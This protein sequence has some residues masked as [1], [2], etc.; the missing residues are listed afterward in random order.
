VRG[1][2]HQVAAQAGG[3]LLRQEAM[4]FANA[5]GVN[6]KKL[7]K[8]AQRLKEAL[9]VGDDPLLVPLLTLTAQVRTSIVFNTETKHLKLIGNLYDNCQEALVQYAEFLQTT[10]TDPEE[11]SRLMPSLSTLAHDYKLEPEVCVPLRSHPSQ[12]GVG[13]GSSP[14]LRTH[15]Q[16]VGLRGRR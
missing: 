12:H 9:L 13:G 7:A 1:L 6:P 15:L 2:L 10:I 14:G 4:T 8:G 11:Y 16:L 3:D 5:M